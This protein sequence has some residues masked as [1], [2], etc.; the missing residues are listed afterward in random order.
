MCK[1]ARIKLIELSSDK[2]RNRKW[3]FNNFYVL[4]S[5]ATNNILFKCTDEYW[6]IQQPI[7]NDKCYQHQT[8]RCCLRSWV[9]VVFCSVVCLV[10]GDVILQPVVGGD[11]KLVGNLHKQLTWR[12]LV[13]YNLIFCSVWVS[14]LSIIIIILKL[15]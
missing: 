8:A 9:L 6:L 3:Q 10:S 13:C 15:N 2:L 5:Y 11:L 4:N 7:V 1:I 14:C 12:F